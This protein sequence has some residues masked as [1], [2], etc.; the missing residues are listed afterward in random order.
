MIG[1]HSPEFS[2]ERVLANVQRYVREHAIGYPV[3][4]DNTFTTWNDYGNRYWPA[5]YLIDKRGVIS[6]LRNRGRGIPSR[7]NGAYRRLLGEA[8]GS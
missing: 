5:I 6:Y 2:Y 3:A 4:I 7:L 8:S 1:V